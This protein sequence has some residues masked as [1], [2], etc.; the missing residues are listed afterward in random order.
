MR[1]IQKHQDQT[2]DE[3]QEIDDLA[4][5]RSVSPARDAA[6]WQGL[7]SW[8]RL[9]RLSSAAVSSPTPSLRTNHKSHQILWLTA[10]DRPLSGVAAA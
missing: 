3:D 7:L 2:Q 1:L 8:P 5:H 9:S 4:Y 10:Q 6:R